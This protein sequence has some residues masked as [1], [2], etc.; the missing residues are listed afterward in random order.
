MRLLPVALVLLTAIAITG[1]GR[2]SATPTTSPVPT[3][4]ATGGLSVFPGS[5]PL[6]LQ[7]PFGGTQQPVHELTPEFRTPDPGVPPGYHSFEERNRSLISLLVTPSTSPL[8]TR[9]TTVAAPTPSFRR[10]H[11]SRT[12]CLEA[13]PSRRLD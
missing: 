6:D 10:T 5:Q 2:G 13:E 1:C 9:S 11:G 8:A 4:S 7:T 12:T 3:A